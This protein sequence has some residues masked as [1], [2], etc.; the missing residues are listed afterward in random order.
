MKIKMKWIIFILAGLLLGILLILTLK[1]RAQISKAYE[2]PVVPGTE[3]W[4]EL[5]THE[6]MAAACQIPEDVLKSMTT[7]A[8]ILSIMK[9]PLAVDL[10]AYDTVA[11]G[12]H[13][14][15]EQFYAIKELETRLAEEKREEYAYPEIDDSEAATE[16]EKF[17]I[18]DLIDQI[19]S[20]NL[21]SFQPS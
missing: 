2:Y 5:K 10:Y 4:E 12:Y 6:Q 21:S 13:A 20:E 17:F 11:D 9:Y 14:M 1:D 16:F 8:L 19:L 15:R 3:E 7:E 18:E